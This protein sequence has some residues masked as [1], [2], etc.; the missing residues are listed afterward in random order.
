M[1]KASSAK[2]VAR[3]SRAGGHTSG[4]SRQVG[5]PAA[6][7]L[8]VVLGLGLVTFARVSGQVGEDAKNPPKVGEHWHA[9]MGTFI[10]DRF[11]TDVADRTPEDPLG[12]HTH[13]DGLA[14]VH[15]FQAAGAGKQATL[16]KFYGQVGMKVSTSAIRMPAAKPF[17]KRTYEVGKTTCDGKPAT[18]KV[19]HWKS[20]LK[21]ASG[22]AASNTV[23]SDPGK[24][25]F[26][27]DGGAYT[28]AFVAKGTKIV[29]PPSSAE[30]TQKASVDSG[31]GSGQPGASL[32]AGQEI[33][34]DL[35][36]SVSSLPAASTPLTDSTEGSTA[37][38]VTESP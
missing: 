3:A 20:A 13:Q 37:P 22:S 1:G 9:A 7:A 26:T 12:I 14:H 16:D 36:G 2:K 32:P 18:I 28:L 25:R 33:P 4:K 15:P 19:V 31:A 6:I 11:V 35:T 5:F 34:P 24:I 10:C 30:I 29:P 23:T 38:A 17:E 8:V 27:E 21:A